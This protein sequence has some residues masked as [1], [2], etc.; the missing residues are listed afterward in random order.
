MKQEKPEVDNLKKTK[1][2]F[3]SKGKILCKM[4]QFLINTIAKISYILYII[5]FYFI[6]RL[7]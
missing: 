4:S 1:N 6:V 3:G 5:L 7:R 2:N